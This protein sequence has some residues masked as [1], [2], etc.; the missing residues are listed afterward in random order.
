MLN[1]K[2]LSR[3][4]NPES[5]NYVVHYLHFLLAI[6]FVQKVLLAQNVTVICI[7]LKKH[8]EIK[9]TLHF[10]RLFGLKK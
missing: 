7:Y 3:L 5:I 8:K 10:K 6:N 1:M 9:S 4:L 2:L